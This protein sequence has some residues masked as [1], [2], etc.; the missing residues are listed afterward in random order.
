[1]SNR[2]FCDQKQ[3]LDLKLQ[4]SSTIIIVVR[5]V[6]DSRTFLSLQCMSTE[7][8]NEEWVMEWQD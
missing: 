1:M 7:V 6:I 5:V 3:L 2:K 8:D 4:K